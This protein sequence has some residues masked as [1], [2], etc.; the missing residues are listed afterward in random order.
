MCCL[1]NEQET[2]EELN[3][4][5]PAVGDYVTTPE[6]LKGEVYSL[7]VL[8][9]LV[10]VVVTLDNDEKEIREYPVGELRFKPRKRYDKNDVN[11]KELKELE[12]LERKEGKSHISDD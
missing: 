10:K 3:S 5:L 4:H 9:Q 2:Y 11:D 12:A 7:N 6:K 8:R 1:K